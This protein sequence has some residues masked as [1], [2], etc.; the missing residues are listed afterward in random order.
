MSKCELC[1][2]TGY[3]GDNGPGIKGNVEYAICECR[4]PKEPTTDELIKEGSLRHPDSFANTIASR[5]ESQQA[6]IA[7]LEKENF[8]KHQSLTNQ[9]K[10]II[11]LTSQIKELEEELE[12]TKGY[13]LNATMNVSNLS[14]KNDKLKAHM[15]EIDREL[16]DQFIGFSIDLGNLQSQLQ[17]SQSALEKYGKH[18]SHCFYLTA[19]I[20]G[21][22]HLPSCSCGLTNSLSQ[23][24]TLKKDDETR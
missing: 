19:V 18:E 16:S 11:N 21:Y 12:R 5:L 13:Q 1:N 23:P 24:S 9:D 4:E 20:G 3:Y 7:E 2:D 15:K 14:V 8:N 17:S 10:D 22:D 6:K